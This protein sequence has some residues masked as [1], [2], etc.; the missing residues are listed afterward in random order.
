MSE[1]T[2]L[3]LAE[4]NA[5]ILG[6]AT[7]LSR[8]VPQLKMRKMFYTGELISAHEVYRLGG[9]EKVVP[10]TQLLSEAKGLAREIASKS[11]I[12]IKLA[13]QA[14]NHIEVMNVISSYRNEQNFSYE[15]F[16]YE[17]SREARLAFIEK[18]P[19]VFKGG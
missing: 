10:L 13:K 4:I 2:R 15:L 17:D 11:P 9:A 3:G 1:N 8:I 16:T 12:A 7:F 19:P 6:G 14:V 5:G 18:R